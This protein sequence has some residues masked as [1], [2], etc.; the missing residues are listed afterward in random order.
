MKL[1]NFRPL[2][3]TFSLKNLPEASFPA[4]G[5]A[6]VSPHG[7]TVRETVGVWFTRY[8]LCSCVYN[9]EPDL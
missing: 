9:C 4:F 1:Y 8:D 3:E 6:R 2:P 7:E 5:P